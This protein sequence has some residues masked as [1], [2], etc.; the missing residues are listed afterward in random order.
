MERFRSG[1]RV[2]V[3]APGHPLEGRR[4]T[5]RRLNV[6]GPGASVRIDGGIEHD[7][8]LIVDGQEYQDITILQPDQ[9]AEVR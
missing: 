8:H 4:G 5:V 9:C 7:Q 2:V 3:V 6:S 1:Q